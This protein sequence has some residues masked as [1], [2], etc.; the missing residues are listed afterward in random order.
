[1]KQHFKEFINPD[2][3]LWEFWLINM[4]T[5]LELHRWK[6][7]TKHYFALLLPIILIII[8]LT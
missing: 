1:M 6:V 5:G 4:F 3:V 8:K 7:K 2:F